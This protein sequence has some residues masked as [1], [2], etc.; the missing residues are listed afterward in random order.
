[1]IKF[2][3]LL[4][5]WSCRGI[6]RYDLLCIWRGNRESPFLCSPRASMKSGL[7]K[8]AKEKCTT[9]EYTPAYNYYTT[10]LLEVALAAKPSPH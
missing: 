10:I 2:P 9:V 6:I 1:M 5:L 8:C 7:M 3:L 4:K